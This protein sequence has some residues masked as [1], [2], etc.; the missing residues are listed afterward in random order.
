[1]QCVFVQG[2]SST[3]R[4]KTAQESEVTASAPEWWD[5]RPGGLLLE[6]ANLGAYVSSAV[7]KRPARMHALLQIC[8][9]RECRHLTEEQGGEIFRLQHARGF[10]ASVCVLQLWSRN[11][12]SHFNTCVVCCV[13]LVLQQGPLCVHAFC[14]SVPAFCVF[15]HRLPKLCGHVLVLKSRRHAKS[16]HCFHNNTKSL[17]GKVLFAL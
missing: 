13:T 12:A 16:R 7:G 1:M 6:E 14:I 5:T 10:L 9:I 3:T 15:G 8:T 2:D 11:R 4:D 17:H